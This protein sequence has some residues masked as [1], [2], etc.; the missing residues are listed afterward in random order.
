MVNI[1]KMIKRKNGDDF[2][3][4]F[5]IG[6]IFAFSKTVQFRGDATPQ[7]QLLYAR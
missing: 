7:P 3:D 5:F 6:E 4:N 2:S 1:R